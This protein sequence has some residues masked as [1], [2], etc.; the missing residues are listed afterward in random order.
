MPV[1]TFCEF[2]YR[3]REGVAVVPTTLHR[4]AQTCFARLED[5]ERGLLQ[6]YSSWGYDTINSFLRGTTDWSYATAMSRTHTA[7]AH[8]R[9][10]QGATTVIHRIFAKCATPQPLVC[11]RGLNARYLP[12]GVQLGRGVT[13]ATLTGRTVLF[14]GYT[15]TSLKLRVAEKFARQSGEGGMVLAMHLPRGFP[16]IPVFGI[17]DLPHEYEV[18]LPH[19]VRG[20]VVGVDPNLAAVPVITLDVT[21]SDQ[22]WAGSGSRRSPP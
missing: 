7:D 12:A 16:A 9:K 11:Y 10:M 15:S 18:L 2:V 5:H 20:R 21:R 6:S 1:Q 4:W 3:G 8:N 17:S 22:R 14:R 19:D 13:P